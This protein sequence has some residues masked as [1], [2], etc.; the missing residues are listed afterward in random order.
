MGK[1]ILY[2]GGGASPLDLPL[3]WEVTRIAVVC[4]T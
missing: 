2:A 3:L 1:K 4:Y